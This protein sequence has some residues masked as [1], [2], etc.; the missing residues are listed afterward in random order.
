M[1]TKIAFMALV[2]SVFAFAASAD[3][4]IVAGIEWIYTV[5][6]GKASVN[7]GRSLSGESVSGSISI[8]SVLGGC[9]VA[10]IDSY[11]FHGCDLASVTIPDSVTALGDYV[12]PDS[13]PAF[14]FPAQFQ[15]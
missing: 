6:D 10:S 14:N 15:R 12:Y 8:P 4:E 2:C 7:G 5:S 9:R 11:A 13:Q 1:K 3:T